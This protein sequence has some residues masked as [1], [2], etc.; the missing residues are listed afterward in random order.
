M[1]AS[2][3]RALRVASYCF[4]EVGQ[5]HQ[6][7]RRYR[8]QIPTRPKTELYNTVNDLW[9]LPK[10]EPGVV[11][12]FSGAGGIRGIKNDRQENHSEAAQAY[13]CAG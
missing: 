4:T 2:R 13:W 7:K 1:R 3:S 12:E 5:F 9:E 10:V 11:C 8:K 6:Y